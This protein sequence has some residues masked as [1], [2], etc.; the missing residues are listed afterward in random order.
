MTALYITIDTE[1]SFGLARRMGGGG[2]AENFASA[3]I[4]ATP[5]GPLGIHYQMD[6]FDAQ[7]IKAVFFVDHKLKIDDPVGA[8]RVQGVGLTDAVDPDRARHDLIGVT[9]RMLAPTS[10]SLW[11]ADR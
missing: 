9:H 8:V 7:G 11:T 3:I 10:V 2:R 4:G 5:T 1:Y 6:R